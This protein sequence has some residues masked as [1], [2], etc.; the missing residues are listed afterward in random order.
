[1]FQ[2]ANATPE[3]LHE[4]FIEMV[5][6]ELKVVLAQTNVRIYF[7]STHR[8]DPKAVVRIEMARQASKGTDGESA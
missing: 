1:M 3:V 6:N 4:K 8:D 2:H 7:T 5:G